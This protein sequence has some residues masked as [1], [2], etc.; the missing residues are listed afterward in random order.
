LKNETW[1]K[2]VVSSAALAALV[3]HLV[4][5]TLRIDAVSLG[6]LTLAV[7]PWLSTLIKSAELP[8]G[9]KIQFQDVKDAAEKITGDAA[10]QVAGTA[11]KPEAKYLLIAQDDPNLALVGLRIEIEKRLRALAQ[12]VG[13][14]RSLPLPRLTE[15][16]QEKG[17]LDP[18]AA[19][20]LKDLIAYGNQAAHGV[21]IAPA[22]ALSA[23]E[24]GPNV[25]AVLD[26]K[27]ASVDEPTERLSG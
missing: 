13:I 9:W 16:L 21:H 14:T 20:G 3:V 19:S 25:L 8:G 6:F 10:S 17:L 12:R 1:L 5:P 27:L 2:A 4:F 22:V 24:Y 11:E 15:E 23:V 26:G 7:L 18:K